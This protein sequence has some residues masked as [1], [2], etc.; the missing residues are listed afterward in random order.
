MEAMFSPHRSSLF[1]LG[2]GRNIPDTAWGHLQ[3]LVTWLRQRGT[4]VA[5]GGTV[6]PGTA[7]RATLPRGSAQ[8]SPQLLLR[9]KGGWGVKG[10][11]PEKAL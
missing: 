2:V 5:P 7:L 10:R 4:N 1:P 6:Y 8:S 11:G 3:C 9:G